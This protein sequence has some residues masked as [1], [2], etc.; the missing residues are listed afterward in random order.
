MYEDKE[1]RIQ[2]HKKQATKVNNQFA[3]ITDDQ[4]DKHEY[5]HANMRAGFRYGAINYHKHMRWLD[6]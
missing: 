5:R 2:R 4:P 1:I 3:T 6:K